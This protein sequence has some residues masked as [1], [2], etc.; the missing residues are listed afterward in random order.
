LAYVELLRRNRGFRALFFATLGSLVGTWLATIA[1]TIEIWDG[2]GSGSWVSAL[3]ISLFVPSIV[4]GLTLGPLVDRLQ[5][6]RLMIAA[7][8]IRA[9]VFCALPFVSSPGAIVV[10]AAATGIANGFFK[11]AVNA[12][13][14]N[15]LEEADLEHG[16]ALFQAAENVTWA[17]GPLVGGAVVALSGPHL[18]YWINAASF[19]FSALLIGRIPATL[20]Q[21]R[22]AL[23]KGHW[24]D[25]GEGFSLLRTCA[26]LQ[27]VVAAWSVAVIGTGCIDVGEVVIAKQSFDAGDFGFGVLFAAGGVGL[28]AG[29]FAGSSVARRLP[30]RTLYGPAILLMAAGYALAAIAP[31]VWVALPAVAIAGL[32]NGAAALYNVLLIQRGVPDLLRGRAFTVA[33]SVSYAALGLA[34]AAAGPVTSA[35]GGRWIWG[36]GGAFCAAAGVVALALAPHLRQS[37][38]TVGSGLEHVEA[39]TL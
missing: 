34:M 16:N 2:T 14:P 15:L 12:G 18:A 25:L 9:G 28:A 3:L 1:L 30:I 35:L 36:I 11:P 19:V 24:R 27:V 7:D 13:M 39:M 23:S 10:L 20:L 37:E 6:R 22:Q 8:L 17:V 4:I 21:S 38:P 33:M 5:R 31:N 29:S 26:P 32:G